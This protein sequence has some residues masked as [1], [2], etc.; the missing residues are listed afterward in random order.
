MAKCR[1]SMNITDLDPRLA[2]A[3]SERKGHFHL[4]T[5]LYGAPEGGG[6][7]WIGHPQHCT[8][9]RRDTAPD[10]KEVSLWPAIAEFKEGPTLQL[11]HPCG[12]MWCLSFCT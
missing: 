7:S 4:C 6:R 2:Q 8:V 3:A 9:I 1:V 11:T 5:D 10:P 12:D